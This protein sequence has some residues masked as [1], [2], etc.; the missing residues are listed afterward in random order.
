VLVV[1]EGEIHFE[2]WFQLQADVLLGK[3]GVI[4]PRL[5]CVTS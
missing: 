2:G 3:Q 5:C 4:E 1:D